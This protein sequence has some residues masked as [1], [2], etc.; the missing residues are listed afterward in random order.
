MRNRPD[1]TA[2]RR[3]T[4]L[5]VGVVL[6]LGIS[7]GRVAVAQLTPESPQVQQAVQQAIKF[8]EEGGGTDSRLGAQALVGLAMLKYGS[9]RDH[10]QIRH[11]AEAVQKTLQGRDPGVLKSNNEIYSLGLATIFLVEL[12]PSTYRR[13]IELLLEILRRTQKPH[14]GWGYAERDTGDT[15]MVQYAALAMW[16]AQRAGFNV[17]QSMVEGLAEWLLRTQDPG[18]GY[19]YQGKVSPNWQPVPQSSVRLSLTAAGLGSLYIC[20]DL[21]G[22]ADQAPQQEEGIPAALREVRDDAPAARKPKTRIDPGLIRAAQ[23]RGNQW[24]AKN[25]EVDTKQWTH[26]YLYALERYMSFR[27]AADGTDAHRIPWYA[28]G[29]AFLLKTQEEKGSWAGQAQATADTA[30]GLLFLMR[31]M[32]KSIEKAHGLGPGL[33][34]GGRGLPKDTSQVEVRRGQVVARPLLGPAEELFAMLDDPAGDSYG[35]AIEQLTDL[36]PDEAQKVF[37]NRPDRLKQLLRDASPQARIAAIHALGVGGHLDGV[38]PLIQ[39]LDDPDGG[40][41]RAARDALRRLARKPAG[42][43][44][45]DAPNGPDRIA[46]IRRWKAWYRAVRPNAEFDN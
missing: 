5:V 38:P 19:G 35:R 27:E 31:S 37:G 10:P 11:A 45:P 29:A 36:T 34:V 43:G 15:S 1:L 42:F 26:Y 6:V 40:V 17:P 46:A 41:V 44:L 28:Q 4:W 23:R 16:E 20:A 13:E 39:A 14:G 22:L 9:N 21:L 8:L 3:P 32:K 12:D 25:F 24:I 2:W 33:M 18:G 30:F 7:S